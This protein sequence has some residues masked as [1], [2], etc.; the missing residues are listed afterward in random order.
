MLLHLMS[1]RQ[2]AEMLF[3]RTSFDCTSCHACS[4]LAFRRRFSSFARRSHSVRVLLACFGRRTWRSSHLVMPL[5]V[6]ALLSSLTEK[7]GKSCEFLKV[8]LDV[9]GLSPLSTWL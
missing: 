7:M 5:V 3:L 1:V 6:G 8:I 4:S 2:S 9:I